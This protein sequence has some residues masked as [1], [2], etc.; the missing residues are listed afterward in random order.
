MSNVPLKKEINNQLQRMIKDLGGDG[1]IEKQIL[2]LKLTEALE[3]TPKFGDRPVLDVGTPQRQWLS[4][5]GALLTR[6]S[7]DRKIKY[8]AS[9]SMLANY[10]VY[11]ITGIQGQVSDAIEE[12]KLQLELDGRGEIGSAYAPGDTYRFFADLKAIIN[13]AEREI[14]VVDPYF[15]VGSGVGPS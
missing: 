8:Q 1:P 13:A 11:S 4:K 14:L 6:L 10:W 15:K 2:L 3:N 7:L 9:F 12:L 5:V